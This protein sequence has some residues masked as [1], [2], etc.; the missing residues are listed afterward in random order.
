[1]CKICVF[2]GT[3]EGRRLI[4]RLSGRGARL[5]AF[6]A[7]EY[8]EVLLGDHE[9]VTVCAGRMDETEM[10]RT[11]ER[12]RFDLLVDATHPY[13]ERVTE[14]LLVACRETETEYLRLLRP[15]SADQDDGVFVPDMCACVEHL[16]HTHGNILLTT[17]SKTLPDFC[18]DT[19]LRERLY[20]R[21]LPMEASLR[22]CAECGVAPDHI[23]AMQG[24]FSEEMNLAM[25]RAVDATVM[26]TKDT[27]G[28]GG[29]GAKISAARR[30]GVKTVIIGRPAQRDG[31]SLDEAAQMVERRFALRPEKKRVALVGVGMGGA[32][33]RTL[34]MERAVREAECLIGA[35]RMLESV[36]T[37]G[38]QVFSA[39]TAK[40]IARVIRENDCR[41]F[42]VLLSG[43]VGFYSGAKGLIEELPDAELEVL[44]GVGSLQYFCARLRRPWENVRAVSL[45]GRDCNLVREVERNAAVFALVGGDNGVGAALARLRDAGFGELRVHVG[46]RLGYPEERISHG[47]VGEFADERWDP[48][49]VLLVENDRSGAAVVTHGLPDEVFERD[50]T[51]MT[52]SEVRSIA[53]S[54]LRL[55]RNAVVYDVGSGS[56]SVSVEA[57]LQATDGR[58]YAVEMKEKALALTRRNAER[59]HLSNLEVVA[60]RAPE[61]LETLPAPTHAFI[62]G[63]TGS[64]AP[65]IRCLLEKN[66]RVRI[67]V[68]TVTLETLAELTSLA[69][70]FDFCDVAEVSVTKPRVLGRYRLMTAQNPVF[71]FTMQNGGDEIG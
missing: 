48:L 25:L 37:A 11:L 68:N 2:A 10:R 21:V 41:R 49:S 62:G 12:E 56:G 55:T 64:L 70:T 51:P 20:V 46:E 63:S 59:F 50:E 26:V 65:I 36:D 54:K 39:V 44:P 38:K 52:K 66:P 19:A 57:A 4:E 18:R 8:G 7:T 5:T 27:G 43:D 34:S 17:G 29:Y 6:V 42:A 71:I 31:M 35:K 13:A 1:M 60:G 33:T 24:P 30:A 40:D 9:D 61:V 47:L 22:V 16:K 53:L 3:T 28:A 67:V 58:V 69:D 15:S 14:S 23:L 45:H 32:E